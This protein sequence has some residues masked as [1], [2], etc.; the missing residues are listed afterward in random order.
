MNCHSLR[1]FLMLQWVPIKKGILMSRKLF[2]T[3]I[4]LLTSVVTLGSDAIAQSMPLLTDPIKVREVE[5]MSNRLDMTSAQQEALLGVYDTYLVDFSRVRMGEIKDFEDDIAVAA[6]TFG[7]MQFNIPERELVEALIRKAQRA[8]KAIHRSDNLFFDEVLGMLTEKQHA[9][10]KRI[11]IAR[12]LEAYQLF[13]VEMLGGLNKG[14]RT[15]MR[16]LYNKLNDEPNAEIDELLDTYDIRYLKQAKDGFDAII[17]TVRLILDH[18]DE[19]NVRGMDQQALMMRFMLDKEAIEDLKQR[20]EILLVP[21]AE[22]AYEMSQL[23]WKTWNRLEILL[24]ED[25]SRKLQEWYFE[26]SFRE[27]V[28]GGDRIDGYFDIALGLNTITDGQRID[29]QELQITF[30]T[31]WSKLTEKHAEVL[32]QSRQKKTIAIMSGDVSTGFEERLST[33]DSTRREYVEKID[34]RI[35]S[36]LG[37]ELVA[38]LQN[39]SPAR[40][41]TGIRGLSFSGSAENSGNV[42]FVSEENGAEIQVI[43]G[44]AEGV[45]L[46]DEEIEAIMQEHGGSGEMIVIDSGGGTAGTSIV[47]SE[48][49]DTAELDID[50]DALDSLELEVDNAKQRI[51]GSASIPQPITPAFPQRAA[52]VL[53]L[54]ESGVMIIEAVYSEYHEKYNQ[55]YNN[56]AL[57]SKIIYDDKTFSGGERMR[58][59]NELSKT[60][61]DAVASLDA[62][63]FDDLVAVTSLA[64]EDVNLKMLENHRNRQRLSAPDDKWGWSGGEGD[65]ID[66]VSLYVLSKDTD[67]LRNEISKESVNAIR[68][69]MQAYHENVSVPHEIYVQAKY[70]L[71]HMQDAMWLMDDIEANPSMAESVQK[72]WRD[73]FTKVR[74]SKRLLLLANQQVMDALLEIIPESDFWTVRM[75]FVQQ[76]YPDVFKKNVDV[77]PQ[78]T[79]A[80]SI[81]SL[82]VSQQSKLES[83]SSTYRY[84]FWNLCEAMIKNHQ[85][86][87][88]ADGA[89]GFM[90]EEDVHRQIRLETLRFERNELN[91][92][93]HMRLRMVL[94]EDQIAL[95]P[96]L[97]PSVAAADE[98]KW[99]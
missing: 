32:E 94:N 33:L 22:Q 99:R 60:A 6:E 34:S 15:H 11:Q 19:L 26:K 62:A 30:D 54:D 37:K 16:R 46:S 67:D 88:S 7:F 76:A 69:A 48:A 84:D 65:T 42:S 68:N 70:D 14:A 23:N 52:V 95:V 36:I 97:R 40:K 72:R 27:A 24:D 89:D 81:P 28:I 38:Q 39:D 51:Y 93:I 79:A 74:D 98:W 8:I 2:T 87:A 61:S 75:E 29:L 55:A 4:I 1:Y 85:S 45:E 58:K 47:L 78:L 44:S 20:G 43:I 63:F 56:V 50:F 18:I 96:G 77:T 71:A 41:V 53:G 80:L 49:I 59:N 91:D 5:L 10:L 86:N 35:D 3:I 66:L 83:L 57:G 64:R 31:K 13:I 92:R 25:D 17:E 12:E 90:N 73:A 21:L 9:E 82:D